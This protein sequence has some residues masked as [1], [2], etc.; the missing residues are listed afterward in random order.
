VAAFADCFH[1]SGCRGRILLDSCL[2][3]GTHD[4]P[5]N[6]HGTHLKITGIGPGNQLTARFMHHQTWGFEAFFAGDSVSFID[7]GTLLPTGFAVIKSAR[8][9][10]RH[11]MELVFTGA[12][13][14]V[15][16]IGDCIENIT[17]TPELTVRNCRFERTNTRGVLV[18]TR[19]KVLIENNTFY[20]TGMQA[21]LI[22]DDA[23]SWYESGA[24]RDVVIRNNR[25]EECGYNL[26]AANY[27][28]AIAPENH[29]L[30]KDSYVHSNIRIENNFFK[31]FSAPILT[32]RSVKGLAFVGNTVTQSDFIHGD[33]S[34][35]AIKLA[36]CKDV[37]VSGN[38]FNTTW[39]SSLDMEGM[40]GKEVKSDLGNIIRE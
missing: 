27:I 32:A 21:I 33:G 16:K 40:V 38:R 18:T 2:A 11:E 13:D 14:V 28:I 29:Q 23:A 5:V 37:T 39:K 6:V 15:P 7:P 25:F 10:D 31:V 3:S 12:S 30:R 22:A 9:I 36:F 4:D 26:T 24:V 20:R 8:L 35:P 34:L 1:F 17:W 19:R